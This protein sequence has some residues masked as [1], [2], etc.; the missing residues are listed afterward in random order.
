MGTLKPCEDAEVLKNPRVGTTA[1]DKAP[2]A[3][4]GPVSKMVE[5]HCRGGKNKKQGQ[6]NK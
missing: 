5:P 1:A 3:K 6:E 4:A 2:A